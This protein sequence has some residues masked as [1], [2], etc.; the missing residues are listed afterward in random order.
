MTLFEL[1]R[2]TR[3]WQKRLRITDWRVTVKFGEASG[4]LGTTDYNPR[5]LFATVEI[6][7]GQ[8]DERYHDGGIEQ[9]LIHEL[10]H[11][12]MHGDRDYVG[13]DVGQERSINVIADALYTAYR[14]RKR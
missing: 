1:R 8:K 4:N 7:P 10:L 3:L 5:E 2:L 14:G 6:K 9:T 12:V 11:I 13:E